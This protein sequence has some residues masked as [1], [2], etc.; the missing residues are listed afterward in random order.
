MGRGIQLAK[1]KIT[2]TTTVTEEIIDEPAVKAGVTRVLAIVDVSGSMR[3]LIAA[4]IEGYNGYLDALL[5]DEATKDATI[6]LVLF[7]EGAP[8][9]VDED[10]ALAQATRLSVA[11]N[12]A[13]GSTALYDAVGVAVT[14]LERHVSPQDK[15]LVAI[16]TD[17]EEN[18]SRIYSHANIKSMIT[19]L[20]E[21]GWAFAYI[22][23]NKEPFAVA[24]SLG[25]SYGSTMA[26]QPTNQGTRN[27]Y[28]TLSQATNSYTTGERGP[29]S[30]FIVPGG[31]VSGTTKL[32]D[33]D[34]DNAGMLVP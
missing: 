8:Q 25:I 2:T 1:K 33:A 32:A 27:V 21:K 31:S 13:R 28:Y 18:A 5:A 11:M 22:G 15:A 6:T 26:Y 16:I 19:R 4:T 30:V 24:A 23:A 9:I 7:S 14:T 20:S 12:L 34:D 3:P 17:G 10:A 29:E